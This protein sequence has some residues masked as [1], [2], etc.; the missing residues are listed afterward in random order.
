MSLCVSL[1]LSAS[2]GVCLCL[3][4]CLSPTVC[5]CLCL[6]V[7]VLV[8]LCLSLCASVCL[9]VISV[10]L[11]PS[12][13]LLTLTLAFDMNFAHTVQP[14]GRCG[15]VLHSLSR[16]T[17][18]QVARHRA[19]PL[20][21]AAAILSGARLQLILPEVLLTIIASLFSNAPLACQHRQLASTPRPKR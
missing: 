18:P 21:D 4:F 6:S 12:V 10:S 9:R 17:H 8:F 5:V 1:S 2:I 20:A 11:R 7:F 19:A 16:L 13:L 14:W 15:R 3:S